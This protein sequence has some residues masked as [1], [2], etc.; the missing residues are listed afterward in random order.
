MY[1][2]AV[3]FK[4]V[5]LLRLLKLVF[6][7]RTKANMY[8]ERALKCRSSNESQHEHHHS[9]DVGG[10]HNAKWGESQPHLVQGETFA[11]LALKKLTYVRCERWEIL[12]EIFLSRGENFLRALLTRATYVFENR[13]A[14]RNVSWLL[15]FVNFQQFG[16]GFFQ[17]FFRLGWK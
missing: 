15:A 12:C 4:G 6:F 17:Q 11:G 5:S 3:S 8:H 1:C 10:S 7:V 14:S 13:T 9:F 2:R 16:I